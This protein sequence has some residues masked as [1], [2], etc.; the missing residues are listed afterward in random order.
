MT[1]DLAALL[2]GQ[3]FAFML[4]F[5][6]FGAGFML[7][8]GIGE[9]YVPARARLLLA[10][11]FTL[12]LLPVLSGRLPPIPAQP[13]EIARLLAIEIIVGLFFGTILRLLLSALETAGMFI[14]FQTGLSNA[15]MFNPAFA[16]QGTLPGA[17][18]STVAVLLLFLTGL[19][20]SLL[21]GLAGTYDVF[22][23]GAPLIYEDI[24]GTMAQIMARVFTI[25]AQMAAPF[26]LIGL[27]MYVPVGVMNRLV[28]QLQV[29]MV[30]M[31]LQ[32][33]V[34]LALFGLTITTILMFWL[35]QFEDIIHGLLLR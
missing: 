13:A 32:V 28:P 14:S 11:G 30:V 7:L 2:S 8:P 6:R 25:S 17:L 22:L 23:P 19:E 1:F 3:V 26:F 24:A 31:P 21:A 16:T 10:A 29:L 9:P 18:L 33:G 4:L 34:G 12:L 27:L 35:R 5:A 20:D 15:T